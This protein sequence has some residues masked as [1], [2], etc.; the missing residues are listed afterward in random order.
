M[1]RRARPGPTGPVAGIRDAIRSGGGGH[2]TGYD[3]EGVCAHC[4]GMLQG[5]FR[6]RAS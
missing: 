2:S 5:G 1:P 4:M 6:E 3:V